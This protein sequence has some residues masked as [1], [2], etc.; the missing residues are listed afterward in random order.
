MLRA[1]ASVLPTVIFQVI[2]FVAMPSEYRCNAI[3][4]IRSRKYD[5][6]GPR[7]IEDLFT[8]IYF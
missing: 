5:V 7:K 3:M 2:G 4:D 8:F 6:G 1:F